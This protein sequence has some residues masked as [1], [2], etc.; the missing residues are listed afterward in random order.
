MTTEK[1][2]VLVIGAGPSG[3]MAASM[4]N[5]NG[6]NVKIVEKTKFPRFVIGESLLTRCMDHFEEAGVLDELKKQNYQVKNGAIF[7]K[8][9]ER[10]EFEFSEQYT[11]GWEWTWQVPRDEF[12]KVIADKVESMGVEIEYEATVTDIKFDGSDS[13]TTV[14]DKDGN[15]KTI[16]A[17]F[18][19][20]AS[21]YGRVIPRLLDLNIPS[22][23]PTRDTLF[24]Q[25]KDVNRPEGPDSNRIVIVAHRPDVWV[26]IIPFSNGN[27]SFGFVGN[28]DYLSQY[29]GTPEEQL[30]TLIASEP[31]IKDRFSGAEM[32]FEPVH[33]GGYSISVKQL[34][35]DGF[36][37]TG[38]ST[39]FLDPVFSAG[40][41]FATESG[42]AAGKLA[43][44][45]LKGENVDWD[46]E[47]VDHIVHGVE[48]FR[49]YIE[50]WYS[51]KLHN[52][53][54][55]DQ[56]DTKIK[57]QICSVLAGYVWDKSNP[58]VAR[59]EKSVEN[60]SNFLEKKKGES[61]A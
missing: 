52:I 33:I 13:T 25:F 55:S 4:V 54:F 57:E 1:V 19:I 17:K 60:L 18:I 29:E 30:R 34:Y 21:G 27:T 46:G 8:G 7:L 5:K 31:L 15:E 36:V 37:L 12:D 23:L 48:T 11:K 42:I 32:I 47:Y 9:E 56:V 53:F 24:T 61:V 35:G 40:V 43:S 6:L 50:A 26:W 2:D 16:E 49:T 45:Q 38:N 22:T 41:T 39:E 28:P 3:T 51:G 14:V 20:D 59:H 58:F 44:R 10:C